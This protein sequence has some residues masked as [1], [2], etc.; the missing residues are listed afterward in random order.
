MA[1]DVSEMPRKVFKFF[2]GVSKVKIAPK[3]AMKGSKAT[4]TNYL[5]F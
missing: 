4:I 5:R 2:D 1:V 3:K